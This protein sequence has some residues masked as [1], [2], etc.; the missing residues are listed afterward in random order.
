MRGWPCTRHRLKRVVCSHCN[1]WFGSSIDKAV[2]DQVATL[3][4]MLQLDSG[5][6]A[7]PPMLGKVKAG[8][9]TINMMSD[10]T[11]EQVA[12][13]FTIRSIGDGRYQLNITA[14]SVEEIAANIPHMAAQTGISEKRLMEILGQSAKPSRLSGS[15]FQWYVRLNSKI[16]SGSVSFRSPPTRRLSSSL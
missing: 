6:G 8:S 13:P 4:N 12:K 10:G 14:R 15:N 1:N 11:L 3:R 7:A 9:D 16:V 5:T 2:A